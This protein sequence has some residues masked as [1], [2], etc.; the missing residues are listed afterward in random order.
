[1]AAG[2]VSD[3]SGSEPALAGRSDAIATPDAPSLRLAL[4]TRLVLG[5]KIEHNG[6]PP[7]CEARGLAQVTRI[8]A[9]RRSCR[10]LGQMQNETAIIELGAYLL[11]FLV[12]G[13]VGG[14]IAW[15]FLAG[16]VRWLQAGLAA[17]AEAGRAAAGG[18]AQA[19]DEAEAWRARHQAEQLER[20]KFETEARRIVALEPELRQALTRAETAGVEKSA[21]QAAAERVPELERSVKALTEEIVDLKTGNARLQ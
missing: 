20:T 16:R 9:R 10:E 18:L 11:F 15:A 12:A 5:T 6:N 7:Y 8:A 19:R 2:K 21:L 1:M 14:V 3:P 13:A 4:G 17:S